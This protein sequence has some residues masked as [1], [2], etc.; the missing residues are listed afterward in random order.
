MT[1]GRNCSPPPP[2]HTHTHIPATTAKDI[3]TL[4]PKDKELSKAGGLNGTATELASGVVTWV[5]AVVI[6][7]SFV[8]S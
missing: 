3:T 2:P 8:Y 6:S 7:L 1:N 4:E 5:S